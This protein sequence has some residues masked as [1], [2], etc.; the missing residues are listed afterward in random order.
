MITKETILLTHEVGL[1]RDIS[2][3]AIFVLECIINKEFT[4]L[5]DFDDR[6]TNK[7]AFIVYKNLQKCGLITY[8][9]KEFE[10]VITD[11]G[12]NFYNLLKNKKVIVEPTEDWIPEY[13]ALWKDHNGVFF[14]D[15]NRSLGSSLRDTSIQINKFIKTYDYLFKLNTPKTLILDATKS[16]L[17]NAKKN[18]FAYCPN[19]Y[20]FIS[21]QIGGKKEELKSD[22]A[23]ACESILAKPIIPVIKRNKSVNE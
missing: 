23:L 19:S 10:F 16:F 20:Y 5:D 15:K 1:P 7:N 14:K 4:L 9:E 21:K 11:K 2:I 17:E 13:L 3:T 8:S 22:L 6:N 18:N 12:N